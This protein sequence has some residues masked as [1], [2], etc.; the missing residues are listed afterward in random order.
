MS[1]QTTRCA[2][3]SASCARWPSW[4]TQELGKTTGVIHRVTQFG[5]FFK[6]SKESKDSKVSGH[7]MEVVCCLVAHCPLEVGCNAFAKFK[8]RRVEQSV[9]RRFGAAGCWQNM[10]LVLLPVQSVLRS[11]AAYSTKQSAIAYDE[12]LKMC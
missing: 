6:V 5:K 11:G 10:R 8:I 7:P 3:R 9:Q 2:E 12:A 4:G 1:S